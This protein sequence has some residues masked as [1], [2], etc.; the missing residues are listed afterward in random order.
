M[1]IAFRLSENRQAERL[2]TKLKIQFNLKS[3]AILKEKLRLNP[4]MENVFRLPENRQAETSSE[5]LKNGAV[6]D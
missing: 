2:S 4:C 3:L 6:L 5:K 1:K